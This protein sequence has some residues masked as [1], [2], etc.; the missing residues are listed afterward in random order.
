MNLISYA[1]RLLFTLSANVEKVGRTSASTGMAAN[2]DSGVFV[3]FRP[4]FFDPEGD[5][6]G[7][8]GKADNVAPM[9]K[10]GE[11]ESLVGVEVGVGRPYD[12]KD[13][14]SAVKRTYTYTI[15]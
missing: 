2:A 14:K 12:E 1:R 3:A 10:A 6:I 13:F 8:V 4:R 9:T 11:E 7:G 15:S 5:P